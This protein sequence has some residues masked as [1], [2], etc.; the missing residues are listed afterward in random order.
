MGHNSNLILAKKNCDQ[1]D[2]Y[3]QQL[4]SLRTD[5]KESLGANV[6]KAH[7]SQ[8]SKLYNPTK[9]PALVFFRNGTPLLYEGAINE[10]AIYQRFDD[11]RSPVVKELSDANFEHLT[12]AATG[13]TTGDWFV[14]L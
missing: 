3:E 13:S 5:L 1:C 11:N 12:Q 14:M 4:I 7:N 2:L 9:E 8:L 10:D 6:V